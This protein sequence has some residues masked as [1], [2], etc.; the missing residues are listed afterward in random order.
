MIVTDRPGLKCM[1]LERTDPCLFLLL[2]LNY[3]MVFNLC[4]HIAY[5][6]AY[7]CG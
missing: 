2:A 7:K 1:H 5:A 4:L 6:Y 3:I